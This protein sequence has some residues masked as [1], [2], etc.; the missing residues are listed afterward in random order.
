[1][2]LPK[3][4]LLVS[5]LFLQFYSSRVDGSIDWTKVKPK[6][7]DSQQPINL[8]LRKSLPQ[9]ERITNG[10]KAEPKQFPYQ[11]GLL[12]HLDQGRAWCGG[13]LISNRWVLTAAHCAVDINGLDIYLGAT[14]RTD[15][16]E[17]WQEIIYVS[18]RDVYVHEGYDAASI[19]NDIALLKLPVKLNFNDY[20]QPAKL[21]RITDDPALTYVGERAI[22]SGWGRI[23]DGMS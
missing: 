14:N 22:A 16:S 13:T 19:T 1:M 5:I 21:P 6:S 23:S 12:I 7:V 10:T 15:S 18:K 8:N 2:F 9:Q 17:R 4:F 20:I 3:S 11:A